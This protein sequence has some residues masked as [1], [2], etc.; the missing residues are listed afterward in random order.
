MTVRNVGFAGWFLLLLLQPVW[1]AWLMP[2]T[3]TAM[4]P[5]LVLCLVPLLLPLLALRNPRRA[6]LWAAIVSLFYFSHGIAEMWA[7]PHLRLLAGL[8]IAFSAVVIV[9][10]GLDGRGG[11]PASREQ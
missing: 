7:H 9:A 8:E 1:H 2:P 5:T 11:G 3:E 4:A 6:L 10:A